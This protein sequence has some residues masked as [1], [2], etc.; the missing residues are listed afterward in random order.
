VLHVVMQRAGRSVLLAAHTHN[1]V[2]NVL[3]KLRQF[4][5]CPFLR[6]AS[7]IDQVCESAVTRGD[8]ELVGA[9]AHR[10]VRTRCTAS[11]D[12][13]GCVRCDIVRCARVSACVDRRATDHCARTESSHRPTQVRTRLLTSL[14][15]MCSRAQCD[16]DDG[17]GRASPAAVASAV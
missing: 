4:E 3:L 7:H 17:V 14:A 2:D 12:E 8:R 10:T 13:W 6:L 1:A 5:W 9:S 16:R 11:S 15:H